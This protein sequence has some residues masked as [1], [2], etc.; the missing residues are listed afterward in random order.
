MRMTGNR[1][2]TIVDQL[3]VKA[4]VAESLEAIALSIDHAPRTPY[5][6][7]EPI[8]VLVL[9]DATARALAGNLRDLAAITRSGL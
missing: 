8:D 9:A 3:R 6:D 4:F 7:A 1:L 5:G 2:A